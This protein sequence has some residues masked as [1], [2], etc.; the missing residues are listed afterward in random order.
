MVDFGLDAPPF[1]IAIAISG[2]GGPAGS[3]AAGRLKLERPLLIMAVSS[4]LSGT[5]TSLVA[6]AAMTRFPL[7]LPVFYAAIA[8]M[9]APQLP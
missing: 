1:G 7:D 3:L 5:I 9:G 2:S 4:V 8:V 6:I